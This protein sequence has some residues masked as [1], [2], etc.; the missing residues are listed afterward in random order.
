[1]PVAVSHLGTCSRAA[2]ASATQSH[3]R[4]SEAATKQQTTHRLVRVM[5][6]SGCQ[7]HPSAPHPP[8]ASAAGVRTS[9]Y[10]AMSRCRTP[11]YQRRSAATTSPHCCC[12]A[13]GCVAAVARALSASALACPSCRCGCCWCAAASTPAAAPAAP[14]TLSSACGCR[15]PH[16]HGVHSGAVVCP[17]RARHHV[18]A[19]VTR[20]GC[21][22]D[23]PPPP[24]PGQGA[25]VPA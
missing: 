5:D 23:V 25:C 17:A 11:W 22:R 20:P 8:A 21:S 19:R 3:T 7:P 2:A 13:G 1:M 24:P 4:L 6:A 18:D 12:S 14:R 16:H 9:T 15:V 10:T